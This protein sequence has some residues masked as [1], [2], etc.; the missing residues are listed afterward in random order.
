MDG[1]TLDYLLII[2]K[3]FILE[4]LIILTHELIHIITALILKLKPT[5][6]YIIPFVIYFEES[7]LKIKFKLLREDPVTSR[8]HYKSI[9]ISS[10]LNYNILLKKLR[11]YNFVGPLFD[12][13]IFIILLSFGLLNVKYSY[14]ALLSLIHLTISSINF[15]NSDG[16]FAIGSKEDSRCAF[17]LIRSFT[18]CGNGKVSESSKRILTDIHMEI[19]ENIVIEEFDVNDLWNFLNN[20]SFFTNSLLSYLNGDLL[21]I[22]NKSFDFFE[23]LIKDFKNIKLYDYRQEEKT[24]IAILYYLIYKKILD[25]K[26]DIKAIDIPNLKFLNPYYEELFNLFFNKSNNLEFLSNNKN[27][28][29]Y[30]S[31]CNGYS[32]LL[33]NLLKYYSN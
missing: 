5:Y 16:K 24:S 28:P 32:K 20:I 30:A 29:S 9:D 25:R 14:L 11:Y 13:I 18:L 7:K 33:K 23:R 31:Y 27:L 17:D 6:V 2:L 26:F 10:K 19:S 21:R 4:Y 22:H 1:L 15:F 8:T 12:F 3:I